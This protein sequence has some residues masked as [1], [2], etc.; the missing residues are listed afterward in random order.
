MKFREGRSLAKWQPGPLE[1]PERV[2]VDVTITER[3]AAFGLHA[4]LSFW[5]FSRKV[6]NVVL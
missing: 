6:I 2:A 4:A 1:G 3:H 5:V